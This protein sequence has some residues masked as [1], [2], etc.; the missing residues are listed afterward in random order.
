MAASVSPALARR[1][2]GNLPRKAQ[3]EGG[4][5]G[6]GHSL[7]ARPR[8]EVR[9]VAFAGATTRAEIRASEAHFFLAKV[10]F[11]SFSPSSSC[12]AVEGAVALALA[13]PRYLFYACPCW[14]A[15]LA[16]RLPRLA[17]WLAG[18]LARQGRKSFSISRFIYSKDSRVMHTTR[19]RR[20]ARCAQCARCARCASRGEPA[21]AGRPPLPPLQR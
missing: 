18:W 16:G 9:R 13:V 11:S 12:E 1:P 21:P 19:D 6:G 5:G 15:A 7:H 14:Q 2:K 4:G 3:G 8:P 20:S 10:S 17:G